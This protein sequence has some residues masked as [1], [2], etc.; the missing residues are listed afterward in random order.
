MTS[1][2]TRHELRGCFF[3]ALAYLATTWISVWLLKYS[4]GNAP[5]A[6]RALVSLLPVIPIGFAIRAVVN[7]VRA[8]DELQRRIDLEALAIAAVVVG[9]GCLT[10]SFLLTADVVNFSARQAM[11]WVFPAQWIAYVVARTMAQRRYR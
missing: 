10:L 7:L 2:T 5:L 11:V 8:G 6:L 1:I 4:L 9:L 3:A